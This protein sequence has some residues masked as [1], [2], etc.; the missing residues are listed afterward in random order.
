MTRILICDD[1]EV[2]CQGLSAILSTNQQMKVVGIANNGAEAL[3]LLAKKEVDLILL[4]LKMPVLNGIQA[5]K[6]IK[7]SYPQIKILILTTYDA[8]DWLFDAIRN[9]ADGYLLKDTSRENLIHAIQEI[10]EGKTPVDTKVAGKLFNKIAKTTQVGPTTLG[11][12][13]N[14]REKQIL[15]GISHGFSNAEIAAE[16]FLSEGTVRNYVSGILKKLEVDDRTQ[17]A[18]LALRYGL[19]E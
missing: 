6:I 15:K 4:D 9:G 18:V 3:D 14:E 12:D 1:Q 13:L 5:T 17:A 16:L 11:Q 10:M 2:V 7:E 19:V 8:D